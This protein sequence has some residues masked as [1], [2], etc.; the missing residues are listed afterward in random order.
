MNYRG[1]TG[2]RYA[3]IENEMQVPEGKRQADRA[4]IKVAR[5]NAPDNRETE[6]GSNHGGRG[7]GPSRLPRRKLKHR[8]GQPFRQLN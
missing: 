6:A 2:K 5:R 7:A 1:T 3:I 4:A 8:G